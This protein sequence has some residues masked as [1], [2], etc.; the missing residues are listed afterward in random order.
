MTIKLLQ[1]DLAHGFRAEYFASIK[2]FHHRVA[3]LVFR[4]HRFLQDWLHFFA[5]TIESGHV[6]IFDHDNDVGVV[7]S[8]RISG[9]YLVIEDN[10]LCFG[11]FVDRLNGLTNLP[12]VVIAQTRF[13]FDKSQRPDGTLG[14]G[15]RAAFGSGAG[16]RAGYLSCADPGK[17]KQEHGN[18][19]FVHAGSLTAPGHT[20][21][22][23][24]DASD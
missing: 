13:R 19:Y 7:H 22:K 9:Q 8:E 6:R 2:P 17:S 24:C 16:S 21:E 3:T 5:Q 15:N 12:Q 23:I 11:R 18:Q 1:S 10:F 14:K 20:G 4:P